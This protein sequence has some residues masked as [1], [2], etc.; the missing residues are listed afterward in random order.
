MK[1]GTW[2]PLPHSI[3]PEPAM[4]EAILDLNTP[5]GLQKPDQSFQFALHALQKAEEY[6]FDF[7]LAAERFMGPDLEAWM[8][9]TAIAARTSKIELMVAVHPGILTPQVVAKMGATL[10]RISTGRFSINIVNGW[11]EEEFNLYSNGGWLVEPE[12][13]YR[14]MKEFVQVLIGLWTKDRFTLDGEFYHVNEGFLATKPYQL[15][16]P[17]IYAASSSQSGKEI[18]AQYGNVFFVA[19]PPHR[20]G[21]HQFH[22]NFQHIAHEIEV[23][24]E[25]SAAYHRQLNYGFSTQVIC[26]SS[27]A[28]AEAAAEALEKRYTNKKGGP[29]AIAARQMGA[30]LIGTPELIAERI[31][32]YE[33]LG[34][35]SMMLKFHP[36]YDGMEIFAR[37][38]IP[39]VRQHSALKS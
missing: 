38:V 29:G 20:P 3:I 13:R 36:V 15:P 7:S 6:G 5:G 31:L 4:D 18:I 27:Q 28:Q 24:K 22:E 21:F 14:R 32:R 2:C 30:G 10:D 8:V 19:L 12:A 11:W 16:H 37:E 34:I 39:L 23:M 33:E 1:F 35:Q 26:A 17:P 9:F 25:K